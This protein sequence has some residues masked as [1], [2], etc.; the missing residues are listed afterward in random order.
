VKTLTAELALSGRAGTRRLRGRTLA[1][2]AAPAGLRLEGLAPFGAP[3]FIL[4]ADGPDSTLLLPRDR[5][6]VRDAAA[7]DIIEAL[8][9][10][11]LGPRELLGLLSG[12]ATAD[13]VATGGTRHGARWIAIALDDGA[14]VY[15]DARNP[16]GIAAARVG[17]L[18]VEYAEFVAGLPHVVRVQSSADAAGA[19]VE[20]DLTIR[21]SQLE[22]NT[23]FEANVFEVKV[24]EDAM[25][26]T[27]DELREGGPLGSDEG[28]A[29]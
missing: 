26:L 18:T 12:C 13:P 17:G 11:R 9:G 20:A 6:V 25:P 28:A 16:R 10:I 7:A 23:T 3:G 4:V 8:T 1:A 24:P 29:F 19:A 27:L 14:A 21:V 2:I 22:T 5:R 15:L